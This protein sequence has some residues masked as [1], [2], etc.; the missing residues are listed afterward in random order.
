[1]CARSRGKATLPIYLLAFV[2]GQGTII[3][4]KWPFTKRVWQNVRYSDPPYS[5]LSKF[6]EPR[7]HVDIRYVF[8]KLQKKHLK[9]SNQVS[10][11]VIN[12]AINSQSRQMHL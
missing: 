1:M 7:A 2:E 9:Y 6:Q 8:K 10:A 12:P 11:M 3:T 4:A 5:A